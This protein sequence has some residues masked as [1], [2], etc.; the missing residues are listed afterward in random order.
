MPM[1]TRS[2][3][4]HNSTSEEDTEESEEDTE[5]PQ[6]LSIP[7]IN[8]AMANVVGQLVPFDDKSETMTTFLLRVKHYILANNVKD[9]LKVSVL[10][11]VLGPKIVSVLED[12]LAP[13]EVDSKSYNELCDTLKSHYKPCTLT[14]VER[15]KFNTRNQQ[16][17]ESISDYVVTLKHMASTCKFGNFLKDALRDK[18]VCGIR[19]DV[20]RQRLLTDELDF[21]DSFKKALTLEEAIKQKTTFSSTA[22]PVNR[23]KA[24]SSKQKEVKVS[25]VPVPDKKV[26]KKLRP[27]YRCG[28]EEHPHFTCPYKK[29]KC[30]SCGS[31]G[32]LK[33]MCKKGQRRVQNVTE[34]I[35]DTCIYHVRST[36]DGPYTKKLSVNKKIITF[37][38]DTGSLYSICSEQTYLENFSLCELRETPVKLTAIWFADTLPMKGVA[39]VS[40]EHNKKTYMLD[41]YVLK[42]GK[43]IIPSLLGR[44]WNKV[45]N[46]VTLPSSVNLVKSQKEILVGK[47]RAKFSNVF[48]GQP[49]KIKQFKA[50]ILLKEGAAPV[51][52][53]ARNIPYALKPAVDAEL[54]RLEETGIITP[55][56]HADWATPLVV[57]PKQS[58]V[59]LCADFKVTLN[60]VI[61]KD[62]Y[63]LPNAKDIFA[64]MA[65]GKVYCVLDLEGAYL[66][67][68]VNPDCADLLVINTHRGLYRY[69]FMPLGL[70]SAPAA[71]QS[72]IDEIL[73][74]VR[75]ALAYFDDVIMWADSEEE[76]YALLETVLG[77]FSKYNIKVNAS[78][79]RFFERK[80]N[81]LGY[82]VSADGVHP[83]GDLLK[84]IQD[85]PVPKD[86]TD[87]KAYLGLINFYHDFIPN[88]SHRLAPLY[89]LTKSDAE[90]KW[91]PDHS[92]LFEESKLWLCKDDVLAYYDP[93][94]PIRL[95]SDGSGKGV[96]SVLAHVIDGKERPIAFAS[97]ILTQAEAG[98][99]QLEREALAIV[100]GIKKFHK[101]L[102]GRHFELVCDNKPLT[103]ILGEKKAIPAMAAARLQR[104]AIL[105]AGYDYTM[106]HKKGTAIGN[107]DYLSRCAIADTEQVERDRNTFSSVKYLESV[108]FCVENGQEQLTA[109]DIGRETQQDEVLRQVFSYIR[110]GWPEKLEDNRFDPFFKKRD[111]LSVEGDCILWGSRVVV[112]DNLQGRILRLL[113]GGHPGIVK[114]KMLARSYVWWPKI[115]ENLE[116]YVRNCDSCQQTRNSSTKAPLH[117]WPVPTR[118][119]QRLHIDFAE[120]RLHGQPRNLFLVVDAYSKWLEVFLMG[121]ITTEKTIERLR[122]LFASYGF[123][124]E[125]VSDNGPQLVS[126]EFTTFLQKNRI[127]HV[128]SPP[129]H[130][131]SNGAI[132][133]CCKITKQG[134]WRQ[135]LDNRGTSLQHKID[136]F[137]Y[138]Y[139]N[140]P[141][142]TTE[143]TPAEVFL[144]WMPRTYLTLLKPS[145]AQFVE[146]RH[147]ALE[148]KVNKNRVTPE[149]REKDLVWVKSRRGEKQS[150]LP[151]EV[152]GRESPLT[153]Q[154]AVRGQNGKQFLHADHLRKRQSHVP[155][156]ENAEAAAPPP[157]PVEPRS[158]RKSLTSG[159]V[160]EVVESATTPVHVPRRTGRVRRP[161]VRFQ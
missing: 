148:D 92:K 52:C 22:E 25:N 127:K 132:E 136:N 30:N 7:S 83:S 17:D 75:K 29:Y 129:Y 102:Y 99:S 100:F 154:V 122:T 152:L 33:N 4:R 13:E 158:P 72:V 18:L 140:T 69:N 141:H 106:I 124:E 16:P 37:E 38:V 26:K 76:L 149:F 111:E 50:S 3:Q 24:G 51:F 28:S 155:Q 49:G 150:W 78:K 68:P 82:T 21:D 79:C 74:G 66:Q 62:H 156:Q 8:I 137:L 65:G 117:H 130:A 134:I 95:T 153:F 115:D 42:S 64:Q 14:I 107:A 6:H 138:H 128:K 101:F 120:I 123:P 114:M 48:D 105:L 90:W 87:V 103:L 116:W 84:A 96:G 139:R 118:R 9:G 157:V 147:R 110:F 1:N 67:L 77:L 43:K 119:W 12:L 97:K 88:A 39:T 70:S 54:D 11:S 31:M 55:V 81:Y 104:W 44:Q 80:V 98:Y 47:L 10:L 121:S 160:P 145:L 89:A 58:G 112:P 109:A 53:K 36:S 135:V 125:I 85:A 34:E 146:Q 15:F 2:T 131:Q 57:V 60:R 151:G 41:L 113:H 91:T 20:I 86:K 93:K 94:L 63:P 133:A 73:K 35:D 32:H 19:D 144:G 40:V 108:L 71:F 56:R 143:K 159:P 59:R 45:L 5:A 142:S 61:V 27:C 46:I 126:D 23:V 161:P